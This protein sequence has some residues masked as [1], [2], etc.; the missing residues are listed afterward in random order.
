MTGDLITSDSTAAVNE[1]LLPQA[2]NIAKEGGG[3]D[4]FSSM[5]LKSTKKDFPIINLISGISTDH[6]YIHSDV[7]GFHSI[8]KLAFSHML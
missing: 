4:I 7:P 3:V 8:L 2:G 1:F 6:V 5:K